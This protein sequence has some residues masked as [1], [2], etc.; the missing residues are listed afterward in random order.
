[1]YS[2]LRERG[3]GALVKNWTGML[4]PFLCVLNLTKYY[5]FGGLK[6]RLFQGLKKCNY[7][8]GVTEIN[9]YNFYGIVQFGGENWRTKN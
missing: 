7:F 1:M 2:D 5:F 6:L 3:G 9:L 8:L 4:V